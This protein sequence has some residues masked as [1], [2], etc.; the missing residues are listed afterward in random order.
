[1]ETKEEKRERESRVLSP[2]PDCLSSKS[3]QLLHGGP[4]QL[5]A[6][7]HQGI[8]SHW[9]HSTSM[10][11][12]A[13][14][15]IRD[16]K[17]CPIESPQGHQP[18]LGCRARSRVTARKLLG[19]VP[20][21]QREAC[22]SDRP[23]NIHRHVLRPRKTRCVR[24]GATVWSLCQL[25]RTG[26]RHCMAWHGRQCACRQASKRPWTGSQARLETRRDG[27]TPA[28]GCVS[29]PVPNRGSPLGTT[30]DSTLWHWATSLDGPLGHCS[31]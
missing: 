29:A 26:I 17:I 5:Q 18:S 10:E 16:S 25:R 28:R 4:H 23:R 19:P 2:I 22:S 7:V 1:M 21:T 20:C 14:S 12:S 8:A 3:L 9:S 13:C 31:S 27:D 30:E 6:S 24:A 11:T 15:Q